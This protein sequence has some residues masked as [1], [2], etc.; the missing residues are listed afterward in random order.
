[1]GQN[2]SIE[3]T[4]HT[5]NPW[6]GCIKVSDGC[7]FC[8]AE[9]LSKRYGHS[10][11]GPKNERRLLSDTHWK[12]PIKWNKEADH[13][14]TRYRVF[15]ASMADVFE[16]AAPADQLERLWKLVALT[17]SLDW[18]ILT[19]RPER[20]AANLPSDWGNGYKNV[21][22]GTSVEDERVVDRIA[23][24]SRIPAVVRFLSL[25]P[26]IGPLSN[27]PLSGIDWAIV[28]GESG[29]NARP[30]NPQWVLDIRE[31]CK[32]AKV[33][34]FFKQ[35]GGINKKKA[36]RQLEGRTYDELP[37]IRSCA[38]VTNIYRSSPLVESV[39]AQ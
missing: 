20:I 1:M 11:W 8:Y 7:K 28:G 21:W 18:Q 13:H 4:T 22:L 14:K 34:F 32:T 27:I 36:G 35:W 26:L 25:E 9:A 6:W 17:P 33:A 39:A 3:W 23:H 10:V 12:Q 37:A 38:P 16:E 19:K 29:S 31:Q 15:C 24:L 30:I 2:T 5:F